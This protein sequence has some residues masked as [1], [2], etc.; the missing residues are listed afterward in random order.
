MVHALALPD[1][2]VHS[3][4]EKVRI[5]RNTYIKEVNK[6]NNS[7]KYA[8]SPKDV[9]TPKLTWFSVADEFLRK[10][11]Q[12]KSAEVN[13]SQN[14][15][16]DD[17]EEEDSTDPGDQ[18]GNKELQQSDYVPRISSVVHPEAK[19]MFKESEVKESAKVVNKRKYHDDSVYRAIKAL[20]A[21]SRSTL[22]EEHEFDTFGKSIAA[23]LKQLPLQQALELQS[24][25]QVMIVESRL[26]L[27]SPRNLVP[28]ASPS[29]EVASS[30]STWTQK[31]SPY[32]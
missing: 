22:L 6:V 26:S 2:N 19:E 3:L 10:C 31:E 14:S 28:D 15:G 8:T 25:F 20:K 24:K 7:K 27:L 17:R 1:L 23:Q 4:R 11:I 9:Y 18:E 12:L 29:K 30:S 21:I 32:Y 5:I 13:S 16:T